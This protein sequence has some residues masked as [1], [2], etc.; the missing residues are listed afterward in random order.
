MDH[1]N[2]RICCAFLSFFWG[3]EKQTSRQA[4]T[5][6]TLIIHFESRGILTI[7]Y[8]YLYIYDYICIYIYIYIYIYICIQAFT[9]PTLTW[10]GFTMN[11][12]K[13]MLNYQP[14]TRKARLL[15]VMLANPPRFG[16]AAATN[17][18]L[19]LALIPRITVKLLEPP[20]WVD[21]HVILIFQLP[22]RKESKVF[23]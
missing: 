19:D 17:S 21:T 20:F 10:T 22:T 5:K 8:V 18:V 3:S 16:D 2:Q 6:K 13:V 23:W 7:S 15:Q 4:V 14:A 11:I 12:R 1:G 9:F